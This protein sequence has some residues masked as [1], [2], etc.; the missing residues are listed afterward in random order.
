MK[1]S[2]NRSESVYNNHQKF[3][4]DG[5]NIE[6]EYVNTAVFCVSKAF[7][8]YKNEYRGGQPAKQIKQSRNGE[9]PP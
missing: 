2:H 6:A 3:G 8:Q 4:Y 1:T 9:N 5:K 7:A